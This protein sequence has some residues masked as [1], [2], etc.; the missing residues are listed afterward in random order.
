MK[1]LLLAAALAAPMAFTAPALAEDTAALARQY[2]EI[3]DVQLMFDDLFSPAALA[4]QF[5]LGLPPGLEISE[6][7]LKRVGDVMGEMMASLRPELTEKMIEGMAEHFTA[8]EL[9]ALIEFYSSPEGASVMRKM[10]PFYQN[11]MVEFLPVIQK[12]QQ[13]YLPALVEILEE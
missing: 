1:H 7:Q 5:R 6:D 13:D 8:G 9:K 10:Q 2:A 11:F 4:E 3:P 12:R